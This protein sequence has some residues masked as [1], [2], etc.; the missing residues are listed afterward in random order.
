QTVQVGRLHR[1]SGGR[2]GA[3][4][5]RGYRRLAAS[6]R[7]SVSHCDGCGLDVA[8]STGYQRGLSVG[9]RRGF[10]STWVGAVNW[11]ELR[12]VWQALLAFAWRKLSRYPWSE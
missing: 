2:Y 4:E 6:E 5:S 10:R 12:L 8:P 3:N 1:T 7:L 11:A 9:A